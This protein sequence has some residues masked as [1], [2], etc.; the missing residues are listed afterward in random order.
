VRTGCYRFRG[1]SVA[2]C[3]VATDVIGIVD[4][5]NRIV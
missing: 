5:T 2:D 1:F 4:I 3:V